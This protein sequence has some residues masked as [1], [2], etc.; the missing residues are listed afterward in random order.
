M[1]DPPVTSGAYVSRPGDGQ[2]EPPPTPVVAGGQ[3][4]ASGWHRDRYIEDLKREL[5]YAK[6]KGDDGYIKA[7]EQQLKRFGQR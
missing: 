2:P 3:T 7:V 4:F 1:S 6:S 5:G